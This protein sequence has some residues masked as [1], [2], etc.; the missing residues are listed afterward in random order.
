MAGPA[1]DY[2]AG[3]LLWLHVR[4]KSVQPG[5]A[6]VFY[7]QSG[8]TEANSVRFYVP[9]GGWQDVTVPMPALGDGWQLRF[10]PPGTSGTCT[11]AR[12]WF[13]E[14]VIYPPPAWPIPTLP[15]IAS[16]AFR[17][18][19]G[20]LGLAHNPDALG[21]FQ[22]SFAGQPVAAGNPEALLGYVFGNQ[23]RWRPFGN[24]PTQPVSSQTFSNG[25]GLR[26]EFTDADG[27]R[28]Q[29]EQRFTSNSPN[30]I[31]VETRVSTDRDRQLLY[32][33]AFTLLAGA[34]SHGTN[35]SQGLLA[36]LEYLENEPSSSELDVMGAAARRLVPDGKKITLPLMAIAASNHC[37]GLIWEPQ[38]DLAPVFDSPDRQFNSGGHLLGLLCPGS[39]G[40]NREEGSL[41]PYSPRVL[42]TNET[43]VAR[44]TI[45]AG[46]GDTV[47][48]AVQQFIALRGLPPVPTTAL[49][50]SNYFRNAA[51][52]WLDSDIRTN[53]LIRHAVWPGFGPQPAADASVWMRW[54]AERVG[55]PLLSAQLSNVAATVLDQVP[56]PALYNSYGVGHVRYPLPALVFGAVLE[57]AARAGSDAQGLLGRFQPDG[58]VLYVPPSGGPDLG[59]THY[60]PDANGLTADVVLSLL[61]KALF[62]GD[63]ALINTGLGRLRA[64]GKFRHTV[65]RGAQTWE[66]PLHTPDILASAHLVLTHLRGYQLTGDPD[67]LEQARYWAWT[68]VPFVYLTPPVPGDVG[69]YAT[70]PVFGATQ[71]VGPWFG[72]PVQWCG[73]VYAE[74]LHQLA[75]LDP[76]SPWQQIAD[77]IAA[78]GTQQAWPPTD[79]ARQG[80]LPDFYLLPE[81][82]SEGPA[83]NPGTLQSQAIQFYTGTRPYRFCALRQHGLFLHAPGDLGD[84]TQS[85]DSVAFTLT[86][87]AASQTRVLMGGFTSVPG[88]ILDGT[89]AP[90]VWPHQFD[91]ARGLLVLGVQ[92]TNRVRILHPALPRL[93]IKS[94]ITNGA[95][96]LS[97]PTANSNFV[98]QQTVTLP[99]LDTWSNSPAPVHVAGDRLVVTEPTTSASR[100][101]RL[102]STQ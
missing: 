58:S 66:V 79:P 7:Y 35:K 44:C 20:E 22:V 82:V 76:A 10:D 18:A 101:F 32:L 2:P 21:A 53:G 43:L 84:V 68:G 56:S 36:G 17:L 93:E 15:T 89:N 45:V 4:L 5:T 100:F 95:I 28:W 23:A 69:L 73:L 40:F 64:L 33:P 34:G 24:S 77:G 57:N 8:P 55:D 92:G 97:W 71:W 65:P 11:L 30:A 99:S 59:S 86:N 54:L 48:P 102:Q 6:Q 26:N 47:V 60:A 74:A 90:I 50:A 41:L 31:A 63:R 70:I 78:S 91:P 51:H 38:P 16:N 13:E 83:I 96:E 49:T 12:I 52:A 75:L 80:L 87:W 25:F 62:S 67:L 37:L 85:V 9:G 14:R 39:D 61:D 98:L 27:A 1:R 42:R 29:I 94:A 81:Q 19:S 3:K 72:K 46:H 88:V